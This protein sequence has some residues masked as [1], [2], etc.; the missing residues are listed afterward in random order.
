VRIFQRHVAPSTG[1]AGDDKVLQI[2]VQRGAN[3]AQP[4]NIRHYLYG[5][6]AETLAGPAERLRADGY[7][8]AVTPAATGTNFLCLAERVQV[9]DYATTASDRKRFEIVASQVPGGEYDGWEASS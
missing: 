2:L 3:L 1:H 7:T 5:Q 6:S 8:V 4:R 9:V